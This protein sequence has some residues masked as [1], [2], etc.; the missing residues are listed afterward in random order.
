MARQLPL[1][2][3]VRVFL[4]STSFGDDHQDP[5]RR[6]RH[7]LAVADRWQAE[8]RLHDD[9]DHRWRRQGIAGARELAGAALHELRVAGALSHEHV[10]ELLRVYGA[11]MRKPTRKPST[12]PTM[13]AAMAN[14]CHDDGDQP[15][16]DRGATNSIM[17]GV[18]PGGPAVAGCDHPR[19]A[20][21]GPL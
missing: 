1:A 7:L 4:K 21:G 11:P 15:P 16:E 14:H 13:P 3:V 20:V 12:A 2:H 18:V 8:R 9:D 10:D 6:A 5:E 17:P 19:A